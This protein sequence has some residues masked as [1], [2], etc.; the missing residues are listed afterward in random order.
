MRE[1]I[2]AGVL[3]L[4]LLSLALCRFVCRELLCKRRAPFG[5][6]CH[7]LDSQLIFGRLVWVDNLTRAAVLLTETEGLTERA[8][9]VCYDEGEARAAHT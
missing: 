7:K 5:P 3:L 6:W 4:S 1:V 2:H 8:D 9:V